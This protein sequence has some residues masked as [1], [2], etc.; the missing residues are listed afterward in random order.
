VSGAAQWLF[1]GALLAGGTLSADAPL[2]D[3]LSAGWQG[4][5]VCEELRTDPGH[6]LLRCTFAPGVGHERHFHPAHIGYALSGGT[7]RIT[8]AKGTREQVLQTGAS[9]TSPGTAWHEV[10]NLG[11]TPVIYLIYEQTAAHG[12]QR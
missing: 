11:T 1:A 9:Y 4:K 10:V 8:D 5:P 3:A 6:R 7:M 2:P 12:A